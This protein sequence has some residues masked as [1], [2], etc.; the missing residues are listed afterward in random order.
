MDKFDCEIYIPHMEKI[1]MDGDT[2][3]V[4]EHVLNKLDKLRRMKQDGKTDNTIGKVTCLIN[5]AN[6]CLLNFYIC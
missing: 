3:L 6:M 1:K 2:I 4:P 5:E